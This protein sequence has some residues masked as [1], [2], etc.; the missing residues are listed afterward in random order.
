MSSKNIETEAKF[1]IPDLT[2]FEA[3]QQVT[4]LGDFNLNPVGA[5][6]IVD[7]YF[8]T[9]EMNIFEAGFACRVRSNTK[10]QQI[11]NLK[12]LA[13]AEGQIHRRQEIEL[14]V[15]TDQPQGWAEGEAKALV[16]GIIGQA[17][18]QTLFTLYQTRY[19]FH[20]YCHKRL[21]IELSLDKVSLHQAETVDYLGLEA[22]LIEDGTET[23]LTRFTETLQR[24]WPLEADTQ[25]KF[26]RGLASRQRKTIKVP[27][28]L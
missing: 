16:M 13:A 17:P 5:K 27:N 10:G 14:E 22:E 4:D 12:S 9:S 1:I 20:V 15:N 3:L 28:S 24:H 6:N 2:T 7:R 19:K 18:L 23:D 26:E 8:D 11:L 21:V 25:S